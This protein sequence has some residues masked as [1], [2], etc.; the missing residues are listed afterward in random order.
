M[1]VLLSLS[2]AKA[3]P[4]SKNEINIVFCMDMS[5]STN[6]LI[7]D[8]KNKIWE[9]I[10]NIHKL[11]PSPVIKIGIIGFS[12]PSFGKNDGYVK[13]ICD[14]TEN[15]D[16][17]SAELNLLK[18][19]IEKGDQFVGA[20]LQTA[21]RMNWCSN[22]KALRIVYLLGNGMVSSG[23]YD[24]RKSCED[25]LR[26][27]IYINSI[28]C[29]QQKIITKE[30]PGWKY[31]SDNTGGE[32]FTYKIRNVSPLSA[33]SADAK[34]LVDLNTQL[35]STYLFFGITGKVR[36]KT[37][38]EADNNCLNMGENYFYSR[39]ICKIT[40]QYQANQAGWDLVNYV[41]AAGI[42]LQNLD[43]DLLPDSLKKFDDIELEKIILEKKDQR[44]LV[45]NQIKTYMQ[46]I[47]YNNQVPDS[48]DLSGIII[49]TTNKL[50]KDKGTFY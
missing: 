41:K 18:P 44:N 12:R 14:L 11:K 16:Q 28:Y 20:A 31:I 25:L 49:N 35:N 39:I 9:V 45:M 1:M 17:V 40:D 23:G 15:Y 43:K 37:M 19:S 26:K 22:P 30:L 5:G 7:P 6:G 13:V 48:S 46:N 50:A 36:M 21:S 24:Y 38:L 2:L 34:V 4:P 42:K 32:H 27:N 29:I 8:F 33:V 47:G 3:G 10:S